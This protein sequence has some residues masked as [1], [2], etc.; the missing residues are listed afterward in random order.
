MADDLKSALDLA[1]EKTDKMIGKEIP[2]L[3]DDQKRRIAET[4]RECEAKIAE[5]KILLAGSEELTVEL[6]KLHRAKEEKIEKIYGET[7]GSG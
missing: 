7:K 6:Q 3:T 5:K 4:K 1:M 2:T